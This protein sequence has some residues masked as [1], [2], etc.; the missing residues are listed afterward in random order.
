[1][2]T[3]G[4]PAMVAGHDDLRAAISPLGRQHPDL[5]ARGK[6]PQLQPAAAARQRCGL[7][8]NARWPHGADPP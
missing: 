5:G 2:R 1:M 6:M 3:A 4:V 8:E 7:S